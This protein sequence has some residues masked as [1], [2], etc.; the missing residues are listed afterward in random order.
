MEKVVS[1]LTMCRL[2]L[3]IQNCFWGLRINQEKSPYPTELQHF[4]LS[5]T[6]LATKLTVQH[7]SVMQVSDIS[8]EFSFP[9]QYMEGV[10]EHI[11][12]WFYLLH[13]H[14]QYLPLTPGLIQSF[15]SDSHENSELGMK[16]SPAVLWEIRVHGFSPRSSFELLRPYMFFPSLVL[17]FCVTLLGLLR[18]P[19][20]RLIIYKHWPRKKTSIPR[21]V[22]VHVAEIASQRLIGK[23]GDKM[24]Q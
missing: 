10:Q 18:T 6:V 23:K 20:F 16:S 13:S 9:L 1:P 24:K 2:P 14:H 5:A 21:L 11:S 4:L 15:F 17:Q 22:R 12:L 8:K 3:H 7:R 19:Q